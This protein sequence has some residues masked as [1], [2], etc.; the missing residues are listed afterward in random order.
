MCSQEWAHY[1]GLVL[2]EHTST[3]SR[4]Y[5]VTLPRDHRDSLRHFLCSATRYPSSVASLREAVAGRGREHRVQC[6]SQALYVPGILAKSTGALLSVIAY[7][8][9]HHPSISLAGFIEPCPC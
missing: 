9:S 5:P 8:L 6:Q 7:T 3:K 1:D 2:T 4:Q